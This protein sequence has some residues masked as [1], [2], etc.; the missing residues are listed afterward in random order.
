MGTFDEL[1]DNFET[2]LIENGVI[3]NPKIKI[4]NFSNIDLGRGLIATDNL[5]SN[6]ILFK[7]PKN[8]IFNMKNNSLIVKYPK[9]YSKLLNINP[10]KSLIIVLY[11]EFKNN[12]NSF[13]FN[14]LK[15]L[16]DS[17][18]DFNQLIFWSPGE[19]KS[20]RPSCILD[21]IGY[22][23]ATEMYDKILK[24]M[25]E[26]AIPEFD[27]DVF[28][29]EKYNI[30]ATLIQSYSFDL[31]EEQ[32]DEDENGDENEEEK[33]EEESIKSMIPLADTLNADTNLNN[34]K[35]FNEGKEYLVMKS[36]KPIFKD[37]QIFNTY[38]DHPNSEI[39]RRYG[40]V[41][42]QGSKFDFGEIPISLIKDFFVEK[43]DITVEY[44]N[45]VFKFIKMICNDEEDDDEKIELILDTYDC[46]KNNQVIIELIFLIQI[47]TI[48]LKIKDEINIEFNQINKIFKKCYQLIEMKRI[49]K[50]FIINFESILQK[51][52]DQYPDIAKEP[53]ENSN[54]ILFD[55]FKMAEVVL[56]SEYQSISNCK[57]NINKTIEKVIGDCKVIAD[58]KLIRSILKKKII[59]D[60]VDTTDVEIDGINGNI[61]GSPGCNIEGIN[62]KKDGPNGLN[63]QNGFTNG[64]LNGYS[65]GRLIGEANGS[66]DVQQVIE[67]KR[68][69]RKRR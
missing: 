24:I 17:I 6:E 3:I 10:W 44:L 32:D 62:G 23:S 37:E 45:S 38:S 53:S 12:Q 67:S 54:N 15:I 26:F 66:I 40:Y 49:T 1:T 42:P 5:E 63:L 64:G 36:I 58:L 28:T 55:R 52:L 39:L 35:L 21:R 2:W 25:E 50:E 41:E 4:H 46:F 59:Q 33:E 65:D 56:K 31:N 8:I 19:L 51:R 11:Y 34:A 57:N 27:K 16:P 29:F 47:L 68:K 14:Y 60:N 7:I 22:D 20:L 30:I 48:I 18:S 61:D 9:L 13:W 43:Y 69:R